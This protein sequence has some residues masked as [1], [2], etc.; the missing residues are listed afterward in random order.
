MARSGINRINKREIDTGAKGSGKEAHKSLELAQRRNFGRVSAQ[1]DATMG[2]VPGC[3]VA[4]S[5]GCLV[6]LRDPARRA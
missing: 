4:E 2:A 5:N 1:I 6:P 3:G